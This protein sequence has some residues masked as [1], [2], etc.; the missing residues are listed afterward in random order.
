MKEIVTYM[1]VNS[2][3]ESQA[4]KYIAATKVI[5]FALKNTIE[6]MLRLGINQNNFFIGGSVA[7]TV[8]GVDLG[9]T[10]HDIDIIVKWEDFETIKER[11]KSSFWFMV[12]PSS[13]SSNVAD[14]CKHFAFKI[15][16]SPI[17]DIMARKTDVPFNKRYITIPNYD[18]A[19]IATLEE[20]IISK[21]IFNRWKDEQ[22]INKIN[23]YIDSLF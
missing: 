16:G 14:G 3:G 20:I 7:A 2:K 19:H 18:L 8:Q 17:I 11:I 1:E 6:L 13:T 5:D 23:S 15:S 10:P 12:L 21:K 22:D 9:R 4:I